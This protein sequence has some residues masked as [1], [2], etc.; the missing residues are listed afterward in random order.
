MTK[1][2]S[3]LQLLGRAIFILLAIGAIGCLAAADTS[4]GMAV[5]NG[6][7]HVNHSRV[8]GN[9]TLFDGSIIETAKSPS[10]LQLKGGAQMRLSTETRVQVYHQKLVLEAG[11]G[12]L[13][14]AAEYEVEARSLRIT[15]ADTHSVARIRLDGDRK[16]MVAAVRG[17]VRVKNASGLLV[18]NVEAGKSLDFEPQAA[19]AA[20]PTRVSGCLLTKAG[21][22]VVVDQTTNTLIELQGTGLDREI[23]NHVEI[24]GSAADGATSVPGASQL[25]RVAGLKQVSKGGC[26]EVARKAG[27]AAVAVGVGVGVG[28]ATGAGSAAGAG[29]GAAAGAAGA[30]GAA[31]AAGVGVGT[32]AVIG[33]VAAAATVGG[34]AAVG[35][36][37]GQSDTPPSASR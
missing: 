15:T 28:T 26:A 6:S 11:L 12:Q 30:A 5:T 23:G 1:K 27:A 16:V 31:T 35:S 3:T 22:I 29:V 14:S 17:T 37:P 33:G 36:L 34:L 9:T 32:I 25:I 24:T 10:Q 21:K 18:A 8:W 4:I 19:G 13:E 20:A 2:P 7:F